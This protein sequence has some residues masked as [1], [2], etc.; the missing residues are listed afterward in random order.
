MTKERIIAEICRT[1]KENGG[2]VLGWRQFE[3]VTGITYYD[4]FGKF[5][6]RWGDAVREAGLEPNRMKEPYSDGLL[7]EKLASLTRKLGRVPVRGDLLL[8]ATGDNSF[9]SESVFRRLGSKRRWA[10]RIIE[11]CE[12]HAGNDDVASLMESSRQS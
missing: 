3:T 1:A 10:V 4:W 5:W 2:A 8:A 12:A 9:P 11:Y 6:T 7:L